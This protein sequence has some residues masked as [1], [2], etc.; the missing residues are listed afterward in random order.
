MIT[1]FQFATS[2]FAEK[3]RRALNY[4]NIPFEIHEVPRAAAAAGEYQYVSP[5]GK[6]PAIQDGDMAVWDSTDIIYHLET[7]SADPYLVPKSPRDAA[8]AHVIEEWADESLYFYEMTVRLTWEHNLDAALDE[9]AA[10]IP[11]VPKPQLK[12]MI[13]QRTSEL[14]STQ[15]IGRKPRDQ[16]TQDIR[17]HFRALNSMLQEQDWL[18]GDDLS[19]ADLAVI[20]QVKA[21]LYATEA[22]SALKETDRVK[23]WMSRVDAKAPA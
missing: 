8:F 23:S 2:P 13:M 20:A 16:I 11:G 5:T 14:T 18:I 21:L 15:G 12:T 3:V 17:R 4:K 1:L 22:Q 19:F 10:T 9:F 7:T 6:F